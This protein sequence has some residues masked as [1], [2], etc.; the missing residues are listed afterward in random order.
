MMEIKG[1][2][3]VALKTVVGQKEIACKNIVMHQLTV[4]EYLEAQA[5][6]KNEHF[7]IVTELA[8]MTKLV[9][10]DGSE[11]QVSYDMLGH[12]SR[13]NLDYLVRLRDDLDAKEQ[14]RT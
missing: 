2:L 4:I 6:A 1:T 7:R 5:N 11:Y 13:V 8:A 14:A 3:P 9:A 10:D 12:S